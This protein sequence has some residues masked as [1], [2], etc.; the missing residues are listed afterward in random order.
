ME[1]YV[2]VYLDTRK[3]GNYLFD[4]MFFEYE[5][6]YIGKGKGRRY[7][8]HLTERL[9]TPNKNIFYK[10]LNNIF[11]SNLEP[12]ILKIKENMS[13]EYAKNHEIYCIKKIGR[14]ID[15]TGTLTNLTE[16]GE[17]TSGYKMSDNTKEKIRQIQLN[18]K[19]WENNIHPMK[20]KSFDE[21]FG[22][23]ISN[24]IKN[25]ISESLI[26]GKSPWKN[27]EISIETKEKISKTLKDLY[28]NI[29]NHPRYGKHM[30]IESREKSSKTHK[31][32]YKLN[33]ITDEY[34]N[35][36]SNK[37]K[38]ENNPSFVIYTII[39]ED[40]NE[41]IELFGRESV[42]SYIMKYKDD[43]NILSKRS[44]SH[45]IL[46]KKFYS[47]PFTLTKYKPNKGNGKYCR[48]N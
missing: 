32:W 21:Y 27:K 11:D 12:I 36:M 33:P 22:I 26:N 13:D 6:I 41:K 47:Y 35:K 39:N 7:L 31:E 34:R 25:K 28:K 24:C 19:R 18:H 9:R 46:L 16:G 15:K 44:P 42:K 48:K 40:N 5:P 29:N 38:G 43:N 1:Y 4:D 20:N 8:Q 2:Y 37:M 45:T 10:K 23:N 17:G 30:S 3:P 14:I